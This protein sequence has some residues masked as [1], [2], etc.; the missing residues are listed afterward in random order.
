MCEDPEPIQI[1]DD[2]TIAHVPQYIS[3]IDSKRIHS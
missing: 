3:F 2:T 1:T